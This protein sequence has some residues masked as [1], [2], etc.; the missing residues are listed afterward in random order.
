ML[1]GCGLGVVESSSHTSTA[2]TSR[3]GCSDDEYE[4]R[5]AFPGSQR[6]PETRKSS[7][8]RTD[9]SQKHSD[10]TVGARV[11]HPKPAKAATPVLALRK[12]T[13][14]MS[15]VE[16][17]TDH[18]CTLVRVRGFGASFQNPYR[19]CLQQSE[20][21]EMAERALCRTRVHVTRGRSIL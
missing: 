18:Q 17:E 13:T 8:E 4:V 10:G 3:R 6:E 11:K 15:H 14:D 9:I 16:K 12:S 1:P 19:C 21:V 5:P 20:R 7:H 2:S